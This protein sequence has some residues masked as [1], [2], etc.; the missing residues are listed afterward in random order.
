MKYYSYRPDANAFAGVGF[1]TDASR[2]VNVHYSDTPMAGSWTAP[3]AHGFEDNPEDNGDFPSLTT[4]RRIPVLS[5]R[6]WDCLRTLIGYCSEAL[7]IV[8]PTGQQYYIIHVMDTID[9]LNEH[10]SELWRNPV[11]G[12][13]GDI[14][15]YALDHGMIEG[16]RIFKLPRESGGELLVD[17]EFRKAVETNRL[18]G[19]LFKELQLV[20]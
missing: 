2:I 19:L 16:K 13:V 3:V 1:A 5:Q 18:K 8:H 20:D 9:A 15:R 11:T 4:F 12:R 6:A 10:R 7:P 14:S 17:D